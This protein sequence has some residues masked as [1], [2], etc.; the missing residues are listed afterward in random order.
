MP[1]RACRKIFH[2]CLLFLRRVHCSPS[3]SGGKQRPPEFLE[4]T[5]LSRSTIPADRR[6]TE[7]WHSSVFLLVVSEQS[8]PSYDTETA[9]SAAGPAADARHT[10][11]TDNSPVCSTACPF[12]APEIPNTAGSPGSGKLHLNKRAAPC[13]S[14][15]RAA[16]C[17]AKNS[18]RKRMNFRSPWYDLTPGS[19]PQMVQ[20]MRPGS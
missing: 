8:V 10:A 11:L 2:S 13:L 12:S 4:H 3:S 17:P 18:L 15:K 9:A 16:D 1:G 14:E 6:K 19:S 5:E 20:L 7:E